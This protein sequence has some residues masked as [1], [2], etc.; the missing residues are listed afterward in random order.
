MSGYLLDTGILIR[1]LRGQKQIV[2]LVRGLS[3]VNRLSVSTVTNL[4]LYAGMHDDERRVTRKLLSRCVN[5]PLDADVAERAGYLVAQGK[6]NNRPIGV[7]DA[8]IAATAIFH[9]ATLVTLNTADFQSVPSLRL[10]KFE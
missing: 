8:I 3:R 6:Q 5:L 7:P 1:H 2:S 4:E 9:Q 10:Y